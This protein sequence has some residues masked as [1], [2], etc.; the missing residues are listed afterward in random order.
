V[1]YK[2]VLSIV[3]HGHYDLIASN[4][5]LKQIGSKRDVRIVIKDNLGQ[6]ELAIFCNENQ[7]SYL[8]P[9]GTKGFGENNN[10]I[11]RYLVLNEI[12]EPD[13]WFLLVNPDVL[14]EP[15]YFSM[16]TDYLLSTDHHFYTPNLFKRKGYDEYDNSLRYFP[17]FR[18]LIS[19]FSRKPITKFYNK[20]ALEDG[21]VIDWGSAAFLC[22]RSAK[23]ELIGG[24]DERYFMYY[25]DVDLCMRLKQ[26]GVDLRFL[27]SIK[28]VHIGHFSNRNLFS[29]HFLW[30][31]KSLFLFL[32]LW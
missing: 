3:S 8:K 32:F 4:D 6:S 12:V 5:W 24:F 21:A 11:H 13:G 19:A 1:K 9:N 22:V 18:D 25:E 15:G 20:D 10:E 17:K 7:I 23:Y 29:K 26:I 27:K 31:L 2:F 14:I 28:A 30:Y 16:L